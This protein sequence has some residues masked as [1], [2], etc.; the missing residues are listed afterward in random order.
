MAEAFLKDLLLITKDGEW[1]K[2][3]PADGLS[4][5]SVIRGADFSDVRV[6]KLNEVPTRFIP[7]HIAERKK[8]QP[9]DILIETA[10]GTRDQPTGRT[11]FLKQ[12]LFEAL[13]RSLICASFSRFLRVN[14]ALA[15]PEFV[16]WYLQSLYA[17]G[18][19]EQHQ[20]QHTGVARFQYTK[21]AETTQ[22]PLPS[23]SE[24]RAIASV[25]GVL[26]DKIELN[27]RT[28]ET[29]E[30]MARALFENRFVDAIQSAL[31][32][33][34]RAAKWGELVTLEY[35]K[36][37]GSYDSDNSGYP[38]YGTNGRIGSH[39]KPLCNHPGIVIGRKGAYRGV[40][41]CDS[42]FFAIDTAFYVEPK[43]PL[44]LRWAYYELLRQ[45]INSMDSGSAIPSTSREDFYNL[46][47]LLPPYELQQR[48]VALLNP[49][50]AKQKQNENESRTLAAL[51]DA[52]LP[53]LLS[54]ELR[55]P[56]AAPLV[57]AR[58]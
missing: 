20:I 28:N 8:L 52:L 42:P 39:S 55:V 50:W 7:T 21:F 30:T 1:G 47:V 49:S 46:S 15:H 10:G 57:E 44:E 32:K 56:A 33:G 12:R 14:P 3:E 9:A 24:Q 11:V 45:D 43:T 38:V 48:F 36:S 5:M 18:E 34:W 6:G 51:R 26:D 2:G 16:Y 4:E 19:M 58:A 41:F 31:L 35:G 37:L 22:I 29:L 53:K 27:Q 25:L 13:P 17:A 23:L 40:H 54:G